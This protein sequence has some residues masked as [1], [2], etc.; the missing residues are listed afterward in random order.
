MSRSSTITGEGWLPNDH[1][2]AI[3]ASEFLDPLD[4]TPQALAAAIGVAPQV[5]AGLID[6]V[7]P[8]SGELDLR[9]TRYF[10]LSAGFFLRLQNSHDLLRA[11]RSLNGELDRIV[12]RAA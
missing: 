3:L 4:L 1:A 9:L 2:G 12:P 10:G 6:G 7:A 5:V 8:I 11:R